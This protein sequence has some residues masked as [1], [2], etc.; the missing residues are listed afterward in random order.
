[1]L[2][3]LEFRYAPSGDF[4]H[5]NAVTNASVLTETK[6]ASFFR[7]LSGT[8]LLCAPAGFVCVLSFG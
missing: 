8:D 6:L 2:V 3:L 1:M 7:T 5:F 4:A